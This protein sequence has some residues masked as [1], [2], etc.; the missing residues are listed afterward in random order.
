MDKEKVLE[1][2]FRDVINQRGISKKLGITA[3]KVRSYHYALKHP[4]R[5]VNVKQIR[6]ILML[7]GMEL[8]QT[9]KWKEKD[10]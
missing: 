3:D 6:Q 1:E 5:S 10:Q 8:V 9:A 7:A 4:E 2:A